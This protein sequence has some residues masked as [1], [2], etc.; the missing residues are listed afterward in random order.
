[1]HFF[2]YI[3]HT[4]AQWFEYAPHGNHCHSNTCSM[5]WFQY[6]V[7][8]ISTK[9]DEFSSESLENAPAQWF[10]IEPHPNIP[11]KSQLI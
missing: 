8:L 7:E 10:D 6:S 4:H 5:T 2:H 3:F 11:T 1:M 9:N